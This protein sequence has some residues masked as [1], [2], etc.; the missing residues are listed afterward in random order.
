MIFKHKSITT[1]YIIGLSILFAFMLLFVNLLIYEEYNDFERDADLIRKT[2]ITA[3][4]KNT[5]SSEAYNIEE[6][7]SN[8]KAELKKRLIKLMMEILSLSVILFG[9]A[10]IWAWIVHYILTRQVEI[11]QD[12]F[13]NASKKYIA[14]DANS[15]ALIEFKNMVPYINNM[16]D[17]I[18]RRKLKLKNIN[19]TLEKKVATKTEDLHIKNKL[20]E[21]ISIH[22]ISLVKSQDS[23]IKHSIHE[24]NTPLAVMLANIDMHKIK[25]GTTEYINKIEAASKVISTIYDDLTYMVKKD[26]IEY[27][28]EWIDMGDFL[29]SRIDFFMEISRGNMHEIKPNITDS[30][31]IF[32]NSIELQRLI[33][34]NI[35]NAIKYS[36]KNSDIEIKLTEN[37]LYITL[38]FHTVTKKIIEDTNKIFSPFHR[39]DTTEL[40]LGL[41]LE[42]VGLICKKENIYIDVSSD[43]EN[44]LFCYKFEKRQIK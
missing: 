33:D 14:I 3:P 9:F 27:T 16:V 28:K 35:S 20:L 15:I 4:T 31:W 34:N 1:I 11:F 10:A 23:F 17:D 22:N 6:E 5:I 40:G 36:K 19:E 13:R 25:F 24:I 43:I 42:I 18:H 2:Y 41:G 29:L 37:K 8:K 26:R 38:K 30:I 44:T 39:E 7:I 21:D 32:F 12:F